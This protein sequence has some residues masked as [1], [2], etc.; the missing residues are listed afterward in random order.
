[1]GG[2]DEKEKR[3]H[4]ASDA[5]CNA[6]PHHHGLT[7]AQ[8]VPKQKQ[9]LPANR[10]PVLQSC[11]VSYDMEYPFEQFRANILLLSPHSFSCL[12]APLTVRTV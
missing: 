5:Q 3:I 6:V 8:T 10:P 12:P 11:M 2:W 9:P 4:K 1:M 7:N